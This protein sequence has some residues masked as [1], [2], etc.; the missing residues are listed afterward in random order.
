MAI[1]WRRDAD[2]AAKER[3]TMTL[4]RWLSLM[5]AWGLPPGEET[6]RELVAAY[7]QKHRHYHTG[8]HIDACLRHL[9][10]CAQALDQPHEVELALWFH[11]AVYS[12]LSSKNE[13][14]SADWARTFLARRRAPPEAI[15]R[16]VDLV[17]ATRHE[18]TTRTKDESFLVDIDLSIL[19]AE[20]P[21]YEA[22]EQAIRKEYRHVPAALYRAGRARLLGRFLARPRIYRNLPF[23]QRENQ[24]RANLAR[25][26]AQ[27]NAGD[28]G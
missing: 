21:V 7:G 6:W 27:L 2:L 14:R 22:F 26:V 4:E 13:R 11:D 25:A 23:T 15:G 16:V 17:M 19:G 9:D 20:P 10:A 3:R 24:A 8:A 12:P 28:G 1:S 18:A 5:E